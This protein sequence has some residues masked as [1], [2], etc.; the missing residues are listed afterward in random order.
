M[1]CLSS[2]LLKGLQ[3]KGKQ[4]GLPQL[5]GSGAFE[6]PHRRLVRPGGVLFQFVAGLVQDARDRRWTGRQGGTTRQH[7]ADALTAPL[8]VVLLEHE[9][10]AFGQIGQAAARL[11]TAWLVHESSRT[12]LVELMLP[13]VERVFGDTDQGGEVAGGQTAAPPGIQQEQALRG[14]QRRRR[15]HG[16]H[17]SAPLGSAVQARQAGG[18]AGVRQRQPAV[19]LGQ[20]SQVH[21]SVVLGRR[22]GWRPLA[23]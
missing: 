9:D 11:L 23:L 17:Q 7:I 13:G 14:G 5:I 3:D 19:V 2:S 4:V 12:L 6:A 8:G 21:A 10:A 18:S 22:A 15:W 16:P 20:G 1:P